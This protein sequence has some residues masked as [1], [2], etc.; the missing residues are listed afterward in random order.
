MKRPFGFYLVLFSVILL[1]I[2]GFINISRKLAWKEPSDGVVWVEGPNGLIARKVAENSPAYLSGIKPGDILFSINN[3]PIK[4]KIEYVKMLWVLDRLE[5]K[6]LYQVGREG[7][8]LAPSF[9]LEKKGVSSTYVYLMLLGLTTLAISLIVFINSRRRFSS[10]YLFFYLVLLSL[11]S[12]F[13]FSPTGQ[14]DWLDQ[15]FFWLDKIA[16]TAFPPLLLNFFFIFPQKK[17]IIDHPRILALIYLPGLF[18][19]LSNLSL[20]TIFQ[21]KL[22]DAEVLNYQRILEKGE[23]LQLAAYSLLTLFMI[24]YDVVATRNLYIKNQLKWIAG[25]LGLGILPFS[26]FYIIPFLG[27]AL[28]STSGQV[29]VLFQIFLPVTLAYSISRYR[30]MDFEVLVKKGLTLIISFALIALVYFLVSSQTQ[31]FSENRLNAI[32]LG[33]LAIILGATLFTPLSEMVQTLVDRVIYRRSYEYRRTLLLISSQL[34]RERDLHRL[35][36]YLVE[37]ISKALSLKNLGLFLAREEQPDSSI[38]FV[39]L[40]SF[41]WPL[42]W[43]S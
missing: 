2:F 27:N 35:A 32:L 23:L 40:A 10:P 8:I 26:I 22:S 43:S 38:F 16:I 36:S 25:G 15:I 42:R 41:I 7:T 21:A 19:I 34:N 33:L 30:L 20:M 14:M 6:A 11:Y 13:V 29:S 17:R 18:L 31:L 37:T 12:V 1:T 9:Y 5:Q 3:T 28:P 24:I 39:P 4:N